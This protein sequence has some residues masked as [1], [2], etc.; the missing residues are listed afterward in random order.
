MYEYG[1]D[2][3]A[4]PISVT[5]SSLK[6]SGEDLKGTQYEESF[7]LWGSKSHPHKVDPL[8]FL[9]ECS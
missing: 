6:I 8:R 9:T 5:N 1:Y 7:M 2:Q 3:Q 4:G